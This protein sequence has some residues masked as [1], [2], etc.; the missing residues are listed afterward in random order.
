LYTAK[1]QRG[2]RDGGSSRT[3]DGRLVV[4]FTLPGAPGTGT[5]P[6]QLF[7]AGGSTCF[8][9]ALQNVAGK[10]KINLPADTAMDAEVDLGLTGPF[11]PGS[12]S[13]R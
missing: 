8:I 1:A 9:G 6:E 11:W 7:A 10:K 3:D 12:S 13:Q 2:D 5:S 4:K